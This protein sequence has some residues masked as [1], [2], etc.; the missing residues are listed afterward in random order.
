MESF[1]NNSPYRLRGFEK[2][3]S[4]R[5]MEHALRKILKKKGKTWTKAKK[6]AEIEKTETNKKN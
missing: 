4:A 5:G 3:E 6:L 2:Q 1:T